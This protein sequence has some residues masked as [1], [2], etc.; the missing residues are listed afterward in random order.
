[1][2]FTAIDVETATNDPFSICQIGLV[3]V[4][5][6]TVK[7]EMCFLVKPPGNVY[8]RWNTLVHG[9]NSSITLKA[10]LFPEVWPLIR[11]HVENS[12]LVAHNAGFD[13][14]C[15]EKTLAYYGL[16]TPELQWDCTL[17]RTGLNL[18]CACDAYGITLSR[19]HDALSDARSCAEI[20]I[21]I[22]EK[23]EPDLSRITPTRKKN[24][25]SFSDHER[26]C[27]ELLKPDLENADPSSPLFN[28]KI[29]FT[30]V[31]SRI[32]RQTAA[33]KAKQLGADIDSGIT[34]R[35]DFMITGSTPGMSKI[36]KVEKYNSEGCNIK[37]L[38]EDEFLELIQYKP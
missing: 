19:H 3:V 34:K 30:G 24:Y 22:M 11:N 1:M 27:G 14:R 6:G 13:S 2:L 17:R 4:A 8:S 33:Q 38:S 25:F 32:D 16:E 37:M 35:T 20:Y 15:M 23:R 36:R 26:L 5:E 29:V 7:N 18:K 28:K 10:P 9:I 21:R 12:V 31:L